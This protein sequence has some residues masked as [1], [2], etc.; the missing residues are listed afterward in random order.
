MGKDAREPDGGTSG[1]TPLSVTRDV[2]T[3]ETGPMA[4]LMRHTRRTVVQRVAAQRVEAGRL[5]RSAMYHLSV[6]TTAGFSPLA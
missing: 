4:P 1:R 3:P 2:Q 6:S 5:P